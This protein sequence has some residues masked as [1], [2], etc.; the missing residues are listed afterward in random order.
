[1][2]GAGFKNFDVMITKYSGFVLL[3]LRNLRGDLSWNV[4]VVSSKKGHV[5][6]FTPFKNL[7]AVVR[8][9]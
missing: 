4:K 9:S 1:L 8:Y 5:L 7:I 6:S 2:A 3:K